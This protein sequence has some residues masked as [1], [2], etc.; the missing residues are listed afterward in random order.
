MNKKTLVSR[1][2]RILLGKKSKKNKQ[3]AGITQ[4]PH[5]NTVTNLDSFFLYYQTKL[6]LK[7][8]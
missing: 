7:L 8:R 5:T 1:I 4:D 2:F 6:G 3:R